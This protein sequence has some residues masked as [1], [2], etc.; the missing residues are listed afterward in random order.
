MVG[1]AQESFLL[2]FAF[3]H[4]TVCEN[5]FGL[6]TNKGF[7][8]NKGEVLSC[9]MTPS[10][11]S[12]EQVPELVNIPEVSEPVTTSAP[13]SQ[14]EPQESE[15]SVT[16]FCD[17]SDLNSHFKNSNLRFNC[18]KKSCT[19]WVYFDLIPIESNFTMI[20]TQIRFLINLCS[21]MF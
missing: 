19:G 2:N 17:V 20:S 9:G 21:R 11:N 3:Y 7:K 12:N 4:M 15:I 8:I 13:Q 6:K 18:G 1:Q 10:S 16:S 14:V 5:N